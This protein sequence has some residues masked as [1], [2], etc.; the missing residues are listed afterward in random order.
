MVKTDPGIDLYRFDLYSYFYGLVRQIE[1]GKVSTYGALARAL[2]D[3]AASRACGF[4]LSINPDPENTPCYRVVKSDS[5]VWKFTHLLGVNEKIRRLNADG[6]SIKDGKVQN[7][8]SLCFNDFKTDFPL[9]A[10]RQ[11]QIRIGELVDLRD[12]GLQEN[13]GAIDVSYD[14]YNGY[15][16]F[17]YSEDGRIEI[18]NCILPVRFPYIPGYLAFRE[19]RFIE[20]LC[21]GFRGTMLVDGNGYLHPRRV[22]LASLAGVLLGVQTIGVAKSLMFGNVRD[23][24]VYSGKERI[25]YMVNKNTIVSAGHMTGLEQSVKFVKSL[26]NGSYPQMLRIAHDSTVKLRTGNTH[27]IGSVRENMAL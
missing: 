7:F 25:G 24:W 5:S 1:R 6:I 2:G 22:G 10:M 3:I 11:Q 14:D 8:E 4:M 13:V 23:G 16:S 17:V 19:Y 15:G 12:H 18:R 27:S 21:R 20:E 9:N 26:N